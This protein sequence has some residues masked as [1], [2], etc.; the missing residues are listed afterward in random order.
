MKIPLYS[1]ELRMAVV[2]NPASLPKEE[3]IP[4]WTESHEDVL[5]LDELKTY[6]VKF[7]EA[8]VPDFFSYMIS[9]GNG[10]CI[11]KKD[12]SENLFEISFA[13]SVG[14]TRI[15]PLRV[16]VIGRKITEEL[17][18]SMLDYI[19]ERF[20]NLVFSFDAPLGQSYNKR[21]PGQ[22]IAY[23]EYLFLKRYLLDGSPNL[24]GIS[25]LILAN[26]HMK[27]CSEYYISS[28]QDISS[29]DSRVLLRTMAMADRFAVL[30]P[31]H[32]LSRTGLGSTL[33]LKTGRELYPSQAFEERRYHTV[34]TNENRFVKYFLERIQH[35][36][37][38]LADALSGV[39]GGFLN[40][41]I[42]KGVDAIGKK[43]NMF[44]SDPFWQDVGL[45]SF[46]PEN[47]Q[48]LQRREGY[49]Q[50]FSLYSILQLCTQ[51]D[52]MS[53]D[54]KNILETKDTPTLFE[55]WAFFVVKDILDATRK[56]VVSCRNIVSENHKEQRVVEGTVIEYE[57]GI[58][59]RFNRS[60]SGTVGYQP[61]DRFSI[62]D[63]GKE[64]YSHG[65]RPDI[66]ISK[67]GKL[68]VLDA[69]YKGKGRN[70]SFYGEDDQGGI[71]SWKE[72]DIDKMHTY[73]E[74]IQNVVGAFILYPGERPVM[75]PAHKAQRLLE[76]VGALPLKPTTGAVPVQ[77]H[78]DDI[79]RVIN[80]FVNEG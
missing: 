32:P 68:L 27:L 16:Q 17:Y 52:F 38:S 6:F 60:C 39:V 3:E 57:G 66:V 44:L 46:M 64:S 73:R 30:P 41:D 50:L 18:H 1:K 67:G 56:K 26:P 70:G 14:M 35:R 29:F 12:Y 19:S 63:N 55:Y 75:Y 21:T 47:S 71:S 36:M 4:S 62:R 40:P 78:R 45:M 59:L 28:I 61:D 33:R 7:Y 74:A 43:I 10:S 65:L 34:D 5:E 69:K 37:G 51:C 49:R 9:R 22:D 23:I 24:D 20:A 42:E 2:E 79:S 72:D 48:V 77:K 8:Q 25:A 80:D 76:G 11:V 53:S 13:N 54:F 58:S 31:G 15:G